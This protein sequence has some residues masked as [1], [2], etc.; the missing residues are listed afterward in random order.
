MKIGFFLFILS[1][2]VFAQNYEIHILEK[3]ETL[4]ELLHKKGYSPLYGKDQWVDRTLKMNHLSSEQDKV[5]RKDFPIILPDKNEKITN[6]ISPN[7]YVQIIRD[8]YKKRYGLLSGKISKHQDLFFEFGYSQKAISLQ[9]TKVNINEN[10]ALKLNIDGKNNYLY[11]QFRY[12]LNG[13][14]GITS[15][16]VGRFENNE[17]RTVNFQPTYIAQTNLLLNTPTIPVNF[18]PSFKLE[19]STSL[20][21]ENDQYQTSRDRLAWIGFKMNKNFILNNSYVFADLNYEKSIMQSSINANNEFTASSLN[22][23]LKLSLTEHYLLGLQTG[24]TQYAQSDIKNEQMIGM[25][26]SYLIK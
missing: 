13:S 2:N 17:I 24:T 26:F 14:V 4:S 6:K 8:D 5:I 7:E 18:G 11:Q 15:H 21:N 10:F 3:G 25:N 1:V 23:D 16:G 12:N 19:E 20:Y 22:F 9:D